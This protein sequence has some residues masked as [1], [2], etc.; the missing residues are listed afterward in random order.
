MPKRMEEI[1]AAIWESVKGKVNPKTKKPY[2]ESD[3]YAIATAT[4]KREQAK[5]EKGVPKKDGSGKGT[6][7]NEGR[8]GC[9]TTKKV[10][11]GRLKWNTK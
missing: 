4:Y 2:V 5:N 9:D 8:G 1:K 10:G 11:Q 7:E 6:R 3:A